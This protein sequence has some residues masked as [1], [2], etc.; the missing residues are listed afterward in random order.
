M[1]FE[2]IRTIII[3]PFNVLVIIPMTLLY[4]TEY[5]WT[6]NY[7]ALLVVG[8][9]LL[10]FGLLFAGWTMWLFGKRG[11]GTAAPWNP[12]K[13]LVVVGPYAHVRNPMITSV[14]T[15][16]IAEAL[17]LNSWLIAVLF[18]VFLIGNMIYFPLFEEKDLEKRFGNSYTQYKRNVPRWLPRLRP[19]LPQSA[20][21]NIPN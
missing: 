19:W 20:A 4:F 11:H 8:G 18:I 15:M 13:K 14:L 10:M 9:V 5:Q 3:L 21:L 1:F 17:L 6:Q 16:L 2:W 12:P 7:S